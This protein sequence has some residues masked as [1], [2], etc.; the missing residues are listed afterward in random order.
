MKKIV[1]LT[2]GLIFT[3]LFSLGVYAASARQGT[4]AG[5]NTLSVTLYDSVYNKGQATVGFTI[6]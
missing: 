3:L 1:I 4:V 6:Q 5:V 2:I